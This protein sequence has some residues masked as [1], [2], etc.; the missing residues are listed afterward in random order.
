M[1]G[2]YLPDVSDPINFT[3]DVMR[4][5]ERRKV[6][7]GSVRSELQGY[8]SA[9][10]SWVDPYGTSGALL[11]QSTQD[12]A[13]AKAAGIHGEQFIQVSAMLLEYT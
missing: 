13:P 3:V 2:Y 12:G 10:Q 9:A 6:S 4:T 1:H 7:L 8:R 11:V 5:A